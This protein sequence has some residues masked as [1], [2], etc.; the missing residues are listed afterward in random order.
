MPAYAKTQVELAAELGITRQTIR[1]W[2]LHPKFP[3]K[4]SRGFNV[5]KAKAWAK[6][7][8][9]GE[10]RRGSGVSTSVA[11][12]TLTEANI[13]KTLE[14]AENERIRKE[15]QLVEQAAELQQ[16]VYLD[17]VRRMLD[18]M[19]A[20]VTAVHD[21][22]GDAVDR[23]MPEAIPEDAATY[24]AMREKVLAYCLKLKEDAAT[25]MRDLAE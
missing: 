19:V 9:K 7:Y 20:T 10:N 22:L 21:A 24:E 25:A 23:A 1:E 2:L 4:T 11:G 13:R 6:E 16:I 14:Q 17:D 5:E 12:V 15:R 18:R 8:R 3:R